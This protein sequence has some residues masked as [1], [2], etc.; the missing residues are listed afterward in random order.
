MSYDATL[1]ITV[2]AALYDTACA[3]ARSLDP[4]SGGAASWGP[5][6]EGATEYTTSTP[7]TSE[8]KAQALAML[9][10]PATLHGAVKADYLARW[11]DLTPPT[12]TK[13]KAFCAAVAVASDQ[14]A[15]APA[16]A[17]TAVP[18]ATPSD[19]GAQA[20]AHA[21]APAP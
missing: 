15:A 6:V 18:T 13:C 5:Q 9:A 4:D 2:P 3:I 19:T 11:P 12:L 7:C 8:F 16:D 14:P 1:T 21:A 20:S 10:D 17:P